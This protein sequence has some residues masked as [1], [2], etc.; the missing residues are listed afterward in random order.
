MPSTVLP[1]RCP[2]QTASMKRRM[3]NN[4][5]ARVLAYVTGLVNQQLQTCDTECLAF[6]KNLIWA[7]PA[8]ALF[9]PHQYGS[10]VPR[11][12]VIPARIQR[13]CVP[14]SFKN[15]A[16]SAA[17]MYADN[18]AGV[19]L[20]AGFT[21]SAN[22]VSLTEIQSGFGN[23]VQDFTNYT[24]ASCSVFCVGTAARQAFRW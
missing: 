15:G 6:V 7:R 9:L 21:P 12:R 4:E 3:K 19:V 14:R 23:D 10:R 1:Q 16:G 18:E 22:A 11:A 24:A 2:L 13:L 8:V 5:W 20:P 17:L